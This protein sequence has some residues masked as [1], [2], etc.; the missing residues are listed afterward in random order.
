MPLILPGN[1]A[2]AT[3]VAGYSIANSCRFNRADSAYMHKTTS[4]GNRKTWT[5]STWIKRGIVSSQQFWGIGQANTTNDNIIVWNFPDSDI[6]TMYDYNGGVSARLDTTQVFRDPSGWYHFVLGV[7][8]EQ[9]TAGN[10]MKLYVNGIRITAFGT[11]TQPAEDYEFNI[12]VADKALTMGIY[13][14]GSL[15]SPVDAYYADTVFIDGTQYAASDFGEFNEDSP[16]IWQP[17]DVSELT[18]GTNGF[19]LNYEDSANLGNDANGGTDLTEVNLAATDQTTDTPTNN[20]CT[21]NPLD[22]FFAA[23]TYTEGNTK[24]VTLVSGGHAFAISTVGL[25]AGKWYAE[26][27]CIATTDSGAYHQVGIVEKIAESVSANIGDT[28][29]SW[30]YF[31]LDGKSRT[32]TSYTTYGDSW[33]TGDIIG[34]F[35]DLDNNKLYFSKN[36]A[37]QNS[38]TG[39]SITAPASNGTGVYFITAGGMSTNASVTFEANFGNPHQALSSAVADANGYGQFEYDPSDGG[40]SSFDS[41]AKDFLAVCT[42]NLGS[43]GG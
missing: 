5:F 24:F 31:G 28:A 32:G 38:G 34:I 15:S 10:R 8:T 12:N 40:G 33:T 22:N 11:E 18:F 23:N 29:Y 1:V 13:N 27:D 43:D 26:F 19:W 7:D 4:A 25:S 30:G 41:A 3:A 16:T 20:F 36:G 9:G 2:S 35:L 14:P 6:I 39:I 21:M 17:K 37:I 42:K